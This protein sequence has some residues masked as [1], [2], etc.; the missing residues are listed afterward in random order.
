VTDD[1]QQRT[2]ANRLALADLCAG[3]TEAEL[4]APSLCAGWSC[5][6]VLGHVVMALEM[7]FPRF[8]LEVARDLGRASRTSDRLAR[9]FGGRPAADLVRVLQERSA[10]VLAPPGVGP[11]GPFADSCIHLRDVA[12]PLGSPVSPPV[13]SWGL[14]LDF[15]LTPR[16]VT[17]GF[18]PRG[19][20][21]GL[22]LTAADRAWTHGEGAE[23]TGPT[24]ALAMAV[25]GRPTGLADLTGAGVSL[26]RARI[27]AG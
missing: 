17:A 2:T 1:V 23:V 10:D 12:V 4:E 6:Q 8:L 26:L 18:V 20:V 25:S 11:L 14:V 27:A 21:A 9:S 22:R 13:E 16:A 19:R 3:R 24:E 15:L 5:R 7:S